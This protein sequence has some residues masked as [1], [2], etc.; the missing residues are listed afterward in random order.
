MNKKAAIAILIITALALPATAVHANVPTMISITRRTDTS[1]NTLIDVKVNHADPTTN[2]YI[3]QITLDLD[4]T[5]ET[6]TSLT[7]TSAVEATYTLNIGKTT[8][9]TIKAQATCNLHGPSAWFTESTTGGNTGGTSSGG[10]DAYPTA[11]V[12][13]GAAL[14][15]TILLNRRQKP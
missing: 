2:H 4:G 14:A 6:F 12:A 13:V 10:I 9:K 3:S 7:K 15:V 11:A 1:G 8:P 5:T